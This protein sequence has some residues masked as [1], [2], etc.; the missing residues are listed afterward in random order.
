MNYSETTLQQWTAPLTQS[1]NQRAE[2]AVWMIK[3]AIRKDE[4]LKSMDIEV[5]IQGSY[6]NN[7]NVRSDSDV[8]VCVM[9][10]DAFKAKF[11]ENK[12]LEDYDFISSDLIFPKYRDMVKRALNA[13]FGSTFVINGNK[14]IKIDENTYHVK[15]DVVPAFQYRNYYYY[16]SYNP[17]EYVEGIYLNSLKG[18]EVINY[19]KVH[20]RNGIDKNISTNKNYKKLVRIMKHIKNNMVSENVIDGDIITSFLIE[21]LV[22]NVPNHLITK[23]GKWND[24][25]IDS[26]SYLYHE[27]KNNRHWR[28]LEVSGMLYLFVGR[29]WTTDDVLNWID[30]TWNYLGYGA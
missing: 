2:N 17:N 5:F 27:I 6:G 18:E 21:S 23:S 22:Y 15:A 25:V 3:D 7:T 8:D 4:E 13:K 29:K 16:T 1:E 19:P 12:T 24:I 9:L 10:K 11:P 28:W 30:K 20:L 14:S 26:L